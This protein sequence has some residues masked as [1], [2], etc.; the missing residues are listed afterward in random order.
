M[1]EIVLV[2]WR[3]R[4][5]V[6]EKE[7]DEEEE[8]KQVGQTYSVQFVAKFSPVIQLNSTHQRSVILPQAEKS[9][10]SRNKKKLPK[11]IFF[12]S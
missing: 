7:R 11:N 2:R 12:L 5:S 9:E 1:R 10:K 4:V 3:E 6:D 8:M